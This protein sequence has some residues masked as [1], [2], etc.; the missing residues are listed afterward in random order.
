MPSLSI[1]DSSLR[2]S[3]PS[4]TP[5]GTKA[6]QNYL[7]TRTKSNPPSEWF[8]YDS[9]AL[10][11]RSKA[12][13]GSLHILADTGSGDDFLKRGQLEP[14]TLEQ[15][16]KDAGREEG[17][18][19]VRMQEGFDHSYYF[20]SAR[21]VALGIAVLLYCRSSVDR[22]R[23]DLDVYARAY[24]VP[25]QVSQGIKQCIQYVLIML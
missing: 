4:K 10:L 24:S 15:A 16:A 18:V 25:R 17:E 11:S 6:F 13:K 21:S 19:Q 20:V 5:W 1:T 7:L 22:K 3:N 2:H 14:R 12:P 23:A 9:S 8:E